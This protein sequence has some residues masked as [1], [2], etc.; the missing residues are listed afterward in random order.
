ML[1]GQATPVATTAT[2]PITQPFTFATTALNAGTYTITASTPPGETT[3]PVTNATVALVTASMANPVGDPTNSLSARVG[4]NEFSFDDSNPGVLNIS[5]QAT[6][7]PNSEAAKAWAE[8][9][10]S[11]SVS[12]ISG[13]TKTWHTSTGAAGDE[14]GSN[15]ICRFTGLPTANSAFGGKTVT[16]TVGATATNRTIEVFFS[17]NATNHPGGDQTPAGWGSERSPNWFYYWNPIV[18]DPDALYNSKV[19]GA[20]AEVPAMTKWSSPLAHSKTAI[21]V[22]PL[23]SGAGWW[24]TIT[25]IDTFAD[26]IKHEN[27]HVTQISQADA[28]LG[29]YVNQNFTLWKGGWSWNTGFNGGMQ[30]HWLPGPD[31]KPGIAGVDDDGDGQIDNL[32]S[33]GEFGAAGSDDVDLDTNDD[34]IPN[35]Y[36]T[37]WPHGTWPHNAGGIVPL[38][39]VE[40]YCMT[41][42]TT[43]EH[44]NWQN[45]WGNAGKQHL[46][47]QDY[48]N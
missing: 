46:L 45:D 17:R 37:A 34:E 16:M 6:L 26:T 29:A 11:W 4:E 27:G 21:W 36:T 24:E 7:V 38:H 31:G 43:N 14:K 2:I 5:C 22:S 39:G 48:T 32:L 40:Y 9:K 44:D 23:A 42:M 41:L 18:G 1:E 30:N 33:I 47:N 35:A 8:E 19:T 12:N 28:L 13:S 20:Y 25:G 15:I 3:L 10:V